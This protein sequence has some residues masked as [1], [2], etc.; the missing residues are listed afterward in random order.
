MATSMAIDLSLHKIVLPLESSKERY[1]GN[2]AR[3]DC[4]DPRVALCLDGFSDIDPS[5]DLGRR[6]LRRRERCWISL[7]VLERG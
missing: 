1:P 6:L 3:A 4:I 2:F 7:F 5:S